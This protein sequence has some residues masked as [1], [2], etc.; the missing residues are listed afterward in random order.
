MAAATTLRGIRGSSEPYGLP[1]TLATLKLVLD[2]VRGRRQP[3]SR[4][5]AYLSPTPVVVVVGEGGQPGG[6]TRGGR[7]HPGPC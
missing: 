5:P 7:L 1:A 2:T 4:R 3:E 6:L